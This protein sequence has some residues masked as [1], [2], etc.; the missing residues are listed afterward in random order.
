MTNRRTPTTYAIL[1]LL[2]RPELDDVRAG[3]AGAAQPQLVLA[4]GRAEAV[5]RAQAAGRRR[6]GRRPRR[7][8][9]ASARGTVLR[10]HRR[11]PRR[12]APLARRAARAADDRVRGAWSSCSSPRPGR[13]SSSR[14]PSTRSPPRPRSGSTCS[15]GRADAA[16]ESRGSPERQHVSTVCR[17]GSRST[18]RSRCCV[19]WTGCANRWRSGPMPQTRAPGTRG[20]CSP[21]WPPTPGRRGG[22]RPAEGRRRL[23][24]SAPPRRSARL[25]LRASAKKCEAGRGELRGVTGSAVFCAFAFGLAGAVGGILARWP[26][27]CA[28]RRGGHPG[29][30]GMIRAR[31]R[32]GKRAS[33]ARPDPLDERRVPDQSRRLPCCGP[34]GPQSSTATRR[35]PRGRRHGCLRD[36]SGCQPGT[37]TR[38]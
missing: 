13:W 1:G 26:T 5:R 38:S 37:P 3:Q 32:G 31:A 28:G 21:S 14:R 4:A 34:C 23:R 36:P 11:R 12:A 30:P 8:R 15:A 25:P 24:G 18:R 20:A 35:R 22:L 33:R 19:G 29:Q 16:I 9:P 2:E 10:H 27:T 7:R 17:C 6:P